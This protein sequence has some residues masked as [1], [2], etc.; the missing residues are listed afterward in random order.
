MNILDVSDAF[1]GLEQPFQF[2][3]QTNHI[4]Q[5]INVPTKQIYNLFG[6]VQPLDLR[7]LKITPT[8]QVA[9]GTHM[10]H[11]RQNLLQKQNI[12][13]TNTVSIIYILIWNNLNFKTVGK[14]LYN[15][16]GYAETDLI[17]MAK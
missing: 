16:Y 17:Q 4:S 5:G 6:V 2:I 10:V 11:I 12:V 9:Y 1:N 15:D 13:L 3:I 8:E 14:W 7:K